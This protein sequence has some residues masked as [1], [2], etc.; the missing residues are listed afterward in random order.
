[1]NSQDYDHLRVDVFMQW[2]SDN[3]KGKN[4]TKDAKTFLNTHIRCKHYCHLHEAGIYADIP[5][6]NVEQSLSV[7][8][9]VKAINSRVA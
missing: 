7:K 2:L 6:I 1:M 5:Q 3:V 4:A 8:K 9:T